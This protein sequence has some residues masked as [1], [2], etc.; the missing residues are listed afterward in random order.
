MPCRERDRAISL[1]LPLD[2]L[3]AKPSQKPEAREPADRGWTGWPPAAQSRRRRAEG[4]GQIPST[5]SDTQ[6]G[7]SKYEVLCSGQKTFQGFQAKGNHRAGM[8]GLGLKSQSQSHEVLGPP[9]LIVGALLCT[10]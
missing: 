2:F 10:L 8:A 4:Q 6:Y 1:Q 3:M 7:F 9:V 5:V